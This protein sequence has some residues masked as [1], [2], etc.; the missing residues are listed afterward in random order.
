MLLGEECPGVLTGA[1]AVHEGEDDLAVEGGP[2]VLDLRM[3]GGA[4]GSSI[5]EAIWL[6]RIMDSA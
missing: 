1:E 4:L 2:H 6:I 5:P 3:R